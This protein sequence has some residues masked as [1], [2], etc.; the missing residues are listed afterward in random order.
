MRFFRSLLSD[1][2]GAT[3][4]EYSLLAAIIGITLAIALGNY[5]DLMNAMFGH[6]GNTY[7][8]AISR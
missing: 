4:V 3:A 6:I 5:Y 1:R 2:S 8:N 7:Q